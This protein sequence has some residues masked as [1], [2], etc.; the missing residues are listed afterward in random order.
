MAESSDNRQVSQ[1]PRHSGERYWS[2]RF[3]RH[4][5]PRGT[6]HRDYST[7]YNRWMYRAKHRALRR[8]LRGFQPS[9]AL[10]VGSGTGWCV[11]KLLRAG[12]SVDGCDI[13][14][15]SVTELRRRH[16]NRGT[17]FFQLAIGEDSIPRPDASY[18]LVT[19]LDVMYHIV[20]RE[21]FEA[22]LTE[23]SRVLRP[24][25]R[26]IVTDGLTG[27][28]RTPAEHVHFRSVDRWRDASASHGL[29]LREVRPL[30]RWLSRPR[31]AGPFRR[32]PD[33]VRGPIEYSLERVAPREAHM[34][35]AVLERVNDRSVR[36]PA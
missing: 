11:E 6:G 19:A 20:S 17:N 33:A 30:Y 7:S 18:E 28:N 2:E 36:P 21:Q 16:G 23:L 14:E 9:R 29:Q 25:G 22:A 32:L 34:H 27:V 35:C 31:E 8:A 4:F 13:T 10:D 24:G 26:M 3:A 15:I 1:N 5:N 12:I